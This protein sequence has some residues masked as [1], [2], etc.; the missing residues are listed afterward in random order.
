VINIDAIWR[1]IAERPDSKA[2][3]PRHYGRRPG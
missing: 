1:L 2:Q 3:L